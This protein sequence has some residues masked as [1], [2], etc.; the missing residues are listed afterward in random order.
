MKACNT[1]AAGVL[2]EARKNG[3]LPQRRTRGARSLTRL[4]AAPWHG[5]L[6][7][8]HPAHRGGRL[9]PAVAIESNILLR[10]KEGQSSR[11]S[12]AGGTL[13]PRRAIYR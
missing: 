6:I 3:R 12:R 10:T 1:K 9:P 4:A 8:L 13:Y 5:S 7:N 2:G 11:R